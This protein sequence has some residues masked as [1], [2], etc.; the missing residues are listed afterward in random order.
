MKWRD[1]HLADGVD[2]LY[3][4]HGGEPSCSPNEVLNIIDTID[5]GKFQIQT[6]GLGNS[7]FYEELIKRKD[8]IDRIGFTYHR[9]AI[10]PNNEAADTTFADNVLRIEKG[11]IPVYVKELLHPE[12]KDEILK[13]KARWENMGIEFRIQDFRSRYGLESIPYTKNEYDLIHHEYKYTH[14]ECQCR[15][16]YKQVL[17]YGYNRL[18]GDVIACWAD[19]VIVGNILKDEYRGGYSVKRIDGNITVQGVEKIYP[20][21]LWEVEENIKNKNAMNAHAINRADELNAE[22]Q[23]IMLQ[24][25]Q[26]TEAALQVQGAIMA[27]EEIAKLGTETAQGLEKI[28]DVEKNYGH[29]A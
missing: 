21:E 24:I 22:L 19:R 6:N 7:D 17:I 11:G 4:L 10:K 29:F 20:P 14:T 23:K 15:A 25:Q 9:Q 2:F 5:K 27:F 8:K 18:A 12:L 26:L 28:V 3:E 1:K 16:G 13:N